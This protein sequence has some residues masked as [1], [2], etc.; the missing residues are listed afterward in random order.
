MDVSG[1]VFA[2]TGGSDG[3]G[4]AAAERLL[5]NGGRVAICGRDAARLDRA[6]A[7]LGGTGAEVIGVPTD[8]TDPDSLAAFFDRIGQTWDRL[9][10]LINGAGY[11][12]GSGFE[13]TSDAEWQLDFELK[14]MAA[15]RGAR[16]AIAM[17]GT[18]GGCILNTLSIW[19]RTPKKGSMPSSV[20]RAAG[21][22]LTKGLANDYADRNIR[23]NAILVGFIESDQWVRSAARA[24]V[25]Y[26]DHLRRMAEDAG[27]P[28]GRVGAARDF[29]ALAAFL[30]SPAASY[31]TGTAIPLD[32]GLSPA[33]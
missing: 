27:I 26:E 2:I 11:H 4:L 30:M 31:I 23:V 29:G 13:H 17:F 15:V 5:A 3:L 19:A 7:R 28:L 1:K 32:G 16:H 10:G 12:T 25:D 22:A 21:L 33:I 24:Q 9:D 18:E 20:F 14:L 8:V 6:L